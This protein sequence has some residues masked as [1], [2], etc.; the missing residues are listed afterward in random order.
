MITVSRAVSLGALHAVPCPLP[1]RENLQALWGL[2]PKVLRVVEMQP[3]FMCTV[4][5]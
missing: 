4:G 5:L 1:T 3:S 2:S